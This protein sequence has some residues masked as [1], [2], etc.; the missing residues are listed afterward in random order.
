MRPFRLASLALAASL[1]GGC[2]ALPL[3]GGHLSVNVPSEVP[4]PAEMTLQLGGS[5]GQA[6]ALSNRVLGALGQASVEQSLGNKLK[7]SALP[8][9]RSTAEQFKSQLEAAKLFG[10]VQHEGGN[11][12]IALGVSR[13]GLAMNPA[14]GNLEPVLDM[15]ASLSAPGLGVVWKASR[16]AKDLGADVMKRA[17]SLGLAQLGARPAGYAEAMNLVLFEL[18]RQLVDDLRKNPPKA[19]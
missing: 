12:G 18:C 11:L 6:A 4:F 15:E 14:N 5:A 16:S 10:S 9:R 13:W 3:I 17:S 1:L 8:L 2:A 19:P 7:E